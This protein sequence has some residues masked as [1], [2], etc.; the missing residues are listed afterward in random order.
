MLSVRRACGPLAAA[1]VLALAASARGEPPS[2]TPAPTTPAPGAPAANTPTDELPIAIAK[3]KGGNTADLARLAESGR[4]DAQALLG[5]YYLNNP[6]VKRDPK[7]ARRWLEKAAAQKHPAASRML[8]ELYASGEGGKRDKKKA[9][10]LWMTSEKGGDVRAPI[11]VADEMFSQLTGGKKPG[12]GQYAFRGGIPVKDIEVVE[13]WYREAQSRD[14]RPETQ[15]RA[16]EALRVLATFKS[17]A[18]AEAKKP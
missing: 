9:M 15:A 5:D 6:A 4:A 13:D 16:T 10:E 8:G 3:A 11:L 2:A 12:P 14:P 1:A 7:E 17:A 18:N